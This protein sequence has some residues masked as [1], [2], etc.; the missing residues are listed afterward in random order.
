MLRLNATTLIPCLQGVIARNQTNITAANDEQM[1][2]R[3]H[4]I[5]VDQV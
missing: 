5:T 4:Q 1:I 3:T 2:S